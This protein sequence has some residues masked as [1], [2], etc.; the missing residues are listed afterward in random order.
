MAD[1]VNACCVVHDSLRGFTLRVYTDSA[2]T[3]GAG[4]LP[5]YSTQS[6]FVFPGATDVQV[7][8]ATFGVVSSRV[9][10]TFLV[11]DAQKTLATDD[12]GRT[13]VNRAT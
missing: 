3:L 2:R 6:T 12:Y 5:E 13:W 11:G 4:L 9:F 1:S 10:A 8:D 7:L